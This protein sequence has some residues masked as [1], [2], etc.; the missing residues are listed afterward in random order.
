MAKRLPAKFRFPKRGLAQSLSLGGIEGQDQNTLPQLLSPN[1]AE[2]KINYIQDGQG[3][4]ES[5]KG[6]KLLIELSEVG[7]THMVWLFDN[8]FLVIF[9]RS[10]GVI[11]ISTQEISIIS[12]FFEYDVTSVVAYGGFVYIATG[13]RGR[14]IALTFLA[15]AYENLVVPF[16]AG[17]ILTDEQTGATA[18]IAGFEGGTPIDPPLI[19]KDRKGIFK[20][21]DTI[22]DELGGEA[23]VKEIA[24]AVTHINEMPAGEKLFVKT[25]EGGGKPGSRLVITQVDGDSKLLRF[26]KVDYSKERA[27]IP[28]IFSDYWDASKTTPDSSGFM[29]FPESI[30]TITSRGDSFIVG[31][32][33]GRTPFQITSATT[34]TEQVQDIKIGWEYKDHGMLQGLDTS[35]GTYYFEPNGFRRMID[36]NTDELLSR[37]LGKD[38]FKDVDVSKATM[39]HDTENNL[40]LASYAKNSFINNEVLA[41]NINTNALTIFKGW[42]LSAFV[43]DDKNVYAT[44]AVE[45]KFFRVFEGFEDD[46]KAIPTELTQTIQNSS[47]THTSIL[48]QLNIQAV[49]FEEDELKV[50]IDIETPQGAFIKDAATFTIIGKASLNALKSWGSAGFGS[51]G[52]SGNSGAVERL[53][54]R[55][56]TDNINV[57]FITAKVRITSLLKTPHIINTVLATVERGNPLE[58]NNITKQNG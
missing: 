14:S 35:S 44:S 23:T 54:Q 16:T 53:E 10:I 42:N 48:R 49:L 37:S 30:K 36:V 27:T 3:R 17:T 51:S 50:H 34:G 43:R 5:R 15:I 18:I 57:E 22:K 45:G 9:G 12:D 55:Y 13:S 58:L 8:N 29:V 11:D 6:L 19:I 31:T 39:V 26:S 20:V 24:I 40:I 4:S 52:W 33:S 21:G 56:H 32:Q 7:I 1:F 28:F 46:G 25:S 41:Y 38:Y 2:T 47:F